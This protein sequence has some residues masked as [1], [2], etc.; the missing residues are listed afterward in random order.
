MNFHLNTELLI[1][2]LT[3]KNKSF[4]K[5]VAK[6]QEEKYG[7]VDIFSASVSADEVDIWF[8]DYGINFYFRNGKVYDT[9]GNGQGHRYQPSL[10]ECAVELHNRV[11]SGELIA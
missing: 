11:W 6:H 4:V 10:Q 7:N 1:Q 9:L 8:G 3:G 2:N 5:R